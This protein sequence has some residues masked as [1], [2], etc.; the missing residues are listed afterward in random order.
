MKIVTMSQC[1]I[2]IQN[3]KRSS[4]DL[5][6]LS[7]KRLYMVKVDHFQDVGE[8]NLLHV[9]IKYTRLQIRQ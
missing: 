8:T 7:R 1:Q 5:P 6:V 2:R 9:L 4:W 3:H